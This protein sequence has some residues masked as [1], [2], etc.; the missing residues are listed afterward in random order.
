MQAQSVL[1]S[2]NTPHE[3]AI[4]FPPEFGVH[5]GWTAAPGESGLSPSHMLDIANQLDAHDQAAG[6]DKDWTST[7]PWAWWFEHHG[8]HENQFT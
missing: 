7:S 1:P 3:I 2:A 8:S 6:L 4:D 5:S